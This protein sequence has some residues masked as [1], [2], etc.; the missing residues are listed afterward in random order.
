MSESRVFGLD[1]VRALAILLVLFSH[2][3]GAFKPLGV[4][5]VELFFVLSGF[6]VGGIFLRV[7]VKEVPF[8]FGALTLFWKRRWWRTLPNYFLFLLVFSTIALYSN[9]F[10]G[11]KRICL[12]PFFL[13]N[14]LW[15]P[16]S[17]FLLSWSL[18]VEEWFYLLMPLFVLFV[19]VFLRKPSSA[20]VCG[21]ILMGGLSCALRV[22]VFNDS[23]WDN[24]ARKISLAR[25]DAL[26]WGCLAAYAHHQSMLLYRWLTSVPGA[27]LAACS[28]V[29]SSVLI[30]RAFP[31]GQAV[32][33][34]TWLLAIVPVSFALLLPSAAAWKSCEGFLASW[35]TN[36]SKWSYSLYLVHIPVFLLVGSFVST[37]DGA[38]AKLVAKLL[39]L[40]GSFVSAALIYRF[41]EVPMM[42]F[43]PRQKLSAQTKAAAA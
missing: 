1:V 23:A 7:R 36:T 25:L 9:D 20:F 28:S 24:V 4:L 41:Y 32:V 3:V 10:P 17:F 29:I 22:G 43:R 31:D 5:G 11:L 35:V 6:L 39:I 8:T 12:Y 18:A 14:W 40:V 33:P 16:D 42:N 2:L 37:G 26:A 13:Q 38:V 34:P 27:L 15:S 19:G 21:C 30:F